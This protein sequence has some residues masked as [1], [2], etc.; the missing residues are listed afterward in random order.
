[1]FKE[2]KFLQQSNNTKLINYAVLDGVLAKPAYHRVT[3]IDHSA[4]F[5]VAYTRGRIDTVDSPD[6][7]YMVARNM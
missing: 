1:M 6:D 4:A 3:Y 2:A 5:R 7:E